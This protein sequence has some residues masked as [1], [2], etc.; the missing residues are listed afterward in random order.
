M[1][2]PSFTVQIIGTG[3][4]FAKRYFNT[5]NLITSSGGKRVLIDCG[6]TVPL[7]LKEGEVALDT[8]DAIFISHI[9]ADHVGGLEEVAYFFKY[10]L[11]R[12]PTLIVAEDIIDTLWEN[13]LK[14]GLAERVEDTIHDFFKIITFKPYQRLSLGD[15]ELRPVPVKHIP[16]KPSYGV[17]VNDTVLFTCDTVF[18]PEL[19]KAAFESHKVKAV[20]HDCQLSG[21]KGTVH[22]TLRE[23][24][25]LPKEYHEKIYLTHYGDDSRNYES[26]AGTGL[27]TLAYQGQR[28]YY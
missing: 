10:I 9:H 8:I 17:Y 15:I 13:T 23:I 2:K 7:A 27:L 1:E 12:K 18:D 5:S 21:E 11:N 4:A 16:G 3:N 26:F 24:L 22:T 28:F 14:G 20:F 25:S 6:S 19:I